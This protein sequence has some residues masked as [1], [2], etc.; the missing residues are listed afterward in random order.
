MFTGEVVA[1]DLDREA[2]TP[3]RIPNIWREFNPR[4]RLVPI[5]SLQFH[6]KDI[7]SLLIGYAEGAAIYS[8]KQNK[9]LK[10]F[11]YEVPR[12]APG[13]DAQSSRINDTRRPSLTHAIWH[14][15]GTFILTA[16]E[17]SSLVF[18]DPRDGRV[19]E[20]RTVQ[21]TGVNQPGRA[22]STSSGSERVTSPQPYFHL[23]WCSKENPDDTGILIAGGSTKSNPTRGLTFMD[24]GATPQYQTSTWDVLGRH[25][26]DPK[27][28]HVLPTP[29]NAEVLDCLLIPRTS[30]YYAGA[31]DPIAVI[32]LLSSGELVTM[33]F[34]SGHPITPTNQLHISLSF[35]QPFVTKTALSCV[36]RTKWLGWRELRQHGPPFA[37]GGAEEMKQLK[38][39]ENRNIVQTAH[40]DGVIRV[41]DAGHGDQIENSTV[42]QVDLARAVGRWDNVEVTEMSFSGAAGELSVG[43]RSGEVVIF[44]LSR[45]KNAGRPPPSIA[46]NEGPGR[47]TDISTRADSGIKEGLLPLSLTND[48]Q[49]PVTALRHSDVGW[50]A[51]GYDSGGVTIIDLRGPAI[52][53]TVLLSDVVAKKRRGSIRH[54]EQ[55]KDR[56]EWPTTMEFGVMTI[57]GDGQCF[58]LYARVRMC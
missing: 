53:H 42:M 23:S 48:Q 22:V 13:G 4:S 36:D 11:V 30:P 14:P 57:E 52:I 18:W 47:M 15:T 49:G 28:L 25:F 38:R 6:P 20:A 1:Y 27:R 8:F 26:R 19:L 54:H 45:N 44:R 37:T 41:W 51:V 58:C 21:D 3:F 32:A 12:G 39:H 2:L 56:T 24:L 35:V 29:P 16:H 33:S 7:G 55:G 43:L 34:P 50:V 10:F 5:V 17:D 40:A 31:H 46:P 9:A